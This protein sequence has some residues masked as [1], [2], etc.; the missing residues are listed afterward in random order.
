ML[1]DNDVFEKLLLNLDAA[2]I[3]S[4]L[5][6]QPELVWQPTQFY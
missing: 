2:A 6:V 3:K 1:H 4:Y 5:D